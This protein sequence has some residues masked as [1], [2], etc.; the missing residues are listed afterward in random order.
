M[1]R[2]QIAKTAAKAAAIAAYK[3]VM[4]KPIE[5][6]KT[7][8]AEV[9]EPK[10]RKLFEFLIGLYGIPSVLVELRRQVGNVPVREHIDT[11][12]RGAEE[13]YPKASFSER[14]IKEMAKIAAAEAYRAVIKLGQAGLQQS[15]NPGAP[16]VT[17]TNLIGATPPPTGGYGNTGPGGMQANLTGLSGKVQYRFPELFKAISQRGERV[18]RAKLLAEWPKA[19]R[20]YSTHPE[21]NK[22]LTIL[23]T[24]APAGL[25]FNVPVPPP[26]PVTGPAA[27][28]PRVTP[29]QPVEDLSG[30]PSKGLGGQSVI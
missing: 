11:A 8:E 14:K 4:G 26:E 15:N 17:N 9:W 25:G 28:R 18:D 21:F 3:S 30:D 24:P 27:G 16:G 6:A 1:N 22:L 19:Y 7:A 10:H 23:N 12:L 2:K 13:M 20:L 29:T 5:M